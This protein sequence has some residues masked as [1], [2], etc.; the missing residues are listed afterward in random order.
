L[1]RDDYFKESQLAPIINVPETF[2]IGA[3]MLAKALSSRSQKS[4]S[5]QRLQLLSAQ[6]PASRVQLEGGFPVGSAYQIVRKWT[7]NI[8]RC[9]WRG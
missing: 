2:E 8:L 7:P 1:I 4:G 6:T 9:V 5:R 3:A